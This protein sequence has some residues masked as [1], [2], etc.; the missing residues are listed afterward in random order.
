VVH[1]L[2]MGS[3][4]R[5]GGGAAPVAICSASSKAAAIAP[6]VPIGVAPPGGITI[7]SRSRA[8]SASPTNGSSA[9]D[10]SRTIRQPIATIAPQF[11]SAHSL[12]GCGNSS[13]AHSR[14]ARGAWIADAMTWFEP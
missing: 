3:T 12:C 11:S 14:P 9:T 10:R 7:A 13:A 4:M 1:V 5:A 6:K 2:P 8:A